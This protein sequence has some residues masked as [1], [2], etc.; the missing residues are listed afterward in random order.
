[1]AGSRRIWA[2]PYY[3]YDKGGRV[4]CE[5]ARV[6]FKKAET[7]K[8][9]WNS[10]CSSASGWERCSLAGALVDEYEEERNHEHE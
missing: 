7:R 1:M 10:Y 5:A 3:R 9:Y 4:Y 2:C 8:K 6:D